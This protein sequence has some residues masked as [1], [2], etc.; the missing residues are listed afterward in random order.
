MR[1][2]LIFTCSSL[3]LFVAG[4]GDDSGS[5]D[6][7]G[8]AMIVAT[9]T[10]LADI[11]Q[12][13]A[14][15]R[16]EAV[17]LLKPNSDPHDYE[18]EPSDAEAFIDASVVVESGGDL[19]EWAGELVES[20][21]TDAPVLTI[22]DSIDTIGEDP[23]WWQNPQNAVIAVE[24]IRDALAEADPDGAGE[25]EDNA[26]AYIA[27][28]ETL[29]GQIE[30]CVGLLPAADR[31]L[32][33]THDALGY[34]ADRYGFEVVGAAIPALTTQAQPSAGETAELVE[35]IR[36][37][38]VRAIFPEAGVNPGLESAIADEADAVIGGELYAD[39]LGGAD[40]P[41]GTYL[42]ALAANTVTITDGL[43]GTG[44]GC[45]LGT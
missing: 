37:E 38:G 5:S 6:T 20:S 22:L 42:G 8:D 23:H 44:L 39:T 14:G 16:A 1:M 32:V 27:D 4:C 12:N 10:Q 9:T 28:I 35:L 11:A 3:L 33:T 15:D 40:T 17:G 21:E 45:D 24:Q 36:D 29:D 19:D 30:Q 34:Y 41:G 2:I 43:A 7:S 31:K 18:P 26:T 13:V 25:Y